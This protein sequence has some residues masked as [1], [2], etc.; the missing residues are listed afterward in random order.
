MYLTGLNET[1]G[2]ASRGKG[3]AN[4]SGANASGRWSGRDLVQ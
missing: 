3:G 4:V 1:V 2:A